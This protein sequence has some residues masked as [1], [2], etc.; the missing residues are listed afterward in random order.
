MLLGLTIAEQDGG[1]IS[2]VQL[3]KRFVFKYS[4]I[5]VGFFSIYFYKIAYIKFAE[6]ALLFVLIIS[7]FYILTQKKQAFHDLFAHNE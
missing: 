1:Q 5:I 6:Y 3:I 4:Y 7:L 2:T